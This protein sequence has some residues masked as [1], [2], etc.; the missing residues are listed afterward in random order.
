MADEEGFRRG[1]P[2]VVGPGPDTPCPNCGCRRI[3]RIEVS[4][5]MLG[6]Q[7][8]N[9]FGVYIGCPA[10]PWASRMAC[11]HVPEIPF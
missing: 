10:C 5:E 6:V 2:Q 4:V 3:F 9:G 7:G 8:N 11:Y 1:V